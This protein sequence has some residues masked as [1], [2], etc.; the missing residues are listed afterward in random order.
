MNTDNKISLDIDDLTPEPTEYIITS[1]PGMAP[2]AIVHTL[3]DARR[4]SRSAQKQGLDGRVW[5]DDEEI[6]DDQD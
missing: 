2:W 4:E 1:K 6:C 5:L 3:A